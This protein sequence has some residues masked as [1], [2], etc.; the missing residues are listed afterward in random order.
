MFG[1][2]NDIINCVDPTIM[3]CWT[4]ISDP[5]RDNPLP[6]ELERSAPPHLRD[7]K[8]AL[9]LKPHQIAFELAVTTWGILQ[10]IRLNFRGA[11]NARL[12]GI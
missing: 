9:R 2:P 8:R 5:D 12:I 11:L 6:A 3:I 7:V 4:G 1:C 10:W